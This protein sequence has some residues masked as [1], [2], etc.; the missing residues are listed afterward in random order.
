MFCAR[1]HH[2]GSPHSTR[3][4]W[5]ARCNGVDHAQLALVRLSS[6][7]STPLLLRVSP[8]QAGSVRNGN[9]M[10][11]RIGLALPARAQRRW[12]RAW[13]VSGLLSL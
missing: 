7:H 13:R 1:F 3:C 5:R 8:V 12:L 6:S 2:Q 4:P 11:M 9:S 10:W